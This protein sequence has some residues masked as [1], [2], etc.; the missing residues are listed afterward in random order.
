MKK[1]QLLA[2]CYGWVVMMGLM[3]SFSII[4]ALFLMYTSLNESMLSWLTLSLGIITLFIGGLIA[5]V[6]SKEKGWL[7]GLMVGC[8]FTLIIFI[9]QF[10]GWKEA[11]S[12]Q[13]ALHHL[14]YILSAI[15]GS[16]IG[17]NTIKQ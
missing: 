1:D 5:G 12:I 4:L 11:F 16:I 8:G 6:K 14:G 13:Q 10:I 17:V 3:I 7:I 2:V 9:I 15:I